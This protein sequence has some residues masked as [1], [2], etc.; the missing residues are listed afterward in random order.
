MKNSLNENDIFVHVNYAESYRNNQQ[1]EIQIWYF[2]NSSFSIFTA[3]CYTKSSD[4]SS[5]T[6]IVTDSVVVVVPYPYSLVEAIEK[7]AFGSPSTLVGQ[8]ELPLG[9]RKFG[10]QLYCSINMFEKSH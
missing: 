2:G 6:G 10:P 5:L 7:G 1:D 9:N 4:P 8:I 3:C